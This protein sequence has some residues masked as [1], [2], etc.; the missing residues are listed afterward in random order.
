LLDENGKEYNS[1]ELA[2]FIEK[3]SLHQSS[4]T[5]V[6]GGAYGFSKEVYARANAKLSLSKNDILTPA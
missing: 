3:Q 6:I 5:F 4:L 1:K 2:G